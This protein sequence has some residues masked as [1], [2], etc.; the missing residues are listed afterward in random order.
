MLT[1]T[2]S[3]K[4]LQMELPNMPLN[5]GG[6]GREIQK[7]EGDAEDGRKEEGEK[8]KEE[9]AREEKEEGRN[10]RGGE[11]KAERRL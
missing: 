9:E 8:E 10:R 11:R 3:R 7:G 2:T 4:N 1:Q 5:V 6:L